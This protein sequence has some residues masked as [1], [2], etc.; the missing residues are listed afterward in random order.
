M[1][2]ENFHVL[3]LDFIHF[4]YSY[5]FY[6]ILFKKLFLY[7]FEMSFLSKS[8]R[9]PLRKTLFSQETE[10]RENDDEDLEIERLEKLLGVS[11]GLKIYYYFLSTSTPNFLL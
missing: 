1:K 3:V 8:K 9:R 10:T 2:N 4:L 6:Y 7:I 5:S 11:K